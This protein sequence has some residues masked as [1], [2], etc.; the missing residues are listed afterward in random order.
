MLVK[1]AYSR[2]L[3]SP[4]LTKKQTLREGEQ[5]KVEAGGEMGD[6]WAVSTPGDFCT[7]R[8]IAIRKRIQAY[9]LHMSF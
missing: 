9:N 7:E 6:V 2:S 8:S 5:M 1:W 3:L 4:T